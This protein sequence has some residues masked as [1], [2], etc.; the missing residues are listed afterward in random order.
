MIH[1]DDGFIKF[2]NNYNIKN[3]Y[4]D[5]GFAVVFEEYECAFP[6]QR[7]ILVVD[8]KLNCFDIEISWD[9]D[10]VVLASELVFFILQQTEFQDES[11]HSYL[12]KE[13]VFEQVINKK[14][15]NIKLYTKN[16][17]DGLVIRYTL[18]YIIDS[19]H[20]DEWFRSIEINSYSKSNN[21]NKNNK[22]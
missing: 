18:A 3:P 2:L 21:D 15:K 12:S 7:K 16:D 5:P 20:P 6:P 8:T 1:R 19:K 10:D 11:L 14:N 17:Y 13:E 9:P 22:K 4:K